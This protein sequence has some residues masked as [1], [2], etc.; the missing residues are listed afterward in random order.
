MAWPPRQWWRLCHWLDNGTGFDPNLVAARLDAAG[1]FVW[2][3]VGGPGFGAAEDV[4][5]GP[6]G[7]VHI[8]GS[9]LGPGTGA[10]GDA[11]VWSLTASGKASDAALWGGTDPFE[12]EF[13]S[14]IA[15]APG[16]ALLVAGIAGQSPYA[17][18]RGSKNAKAVSTFNIPIN[19]TAA[20]PGIT[21]GD[22]A[23][24]VGTPAGSQAFA[25]VTDAFL[26]RVQQ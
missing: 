12:P 3:R 24:V 8:T 19:G 1:N 23:A 7:N 11:F 18:M 22:S 10:G 2:Q 6:E 15:A 17:L 25:G 26:V 21:P 13:G 9:V 5:V 4:A 14:S 16:G 20:D